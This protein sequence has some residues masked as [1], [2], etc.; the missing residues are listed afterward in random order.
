MESVSHTRRIGL[1]PHSPTIAAHSAP[2]FC[3]T[4]TR[5]QFAGPTSTI[6]CSHPARN[7]EGNVTFVLRA[8]LKR[9]TGDFGRRLDIDRIDQF[10][11]GS[12]GEGPPPPH[13]LIELTQLNL[14]LKRSDY[15]SARCHDGNRTWNAKARFTYT[16]DESQTARVR[17]LC[18]VAS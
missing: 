11:V 14:T 15:V 18:H 10:Q 1:E 6:D 9:A 8:E 4:Y 13:P 12:S 5:W 2:R 16:D 3:G 7:T 17:Q